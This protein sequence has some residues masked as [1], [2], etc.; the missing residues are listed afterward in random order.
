[1]TRGPSSPKLPLEVRT[2]WR[3]GN[4]LNGTPGTHLDLIWYSSDGF[5]ADLLALAGTTI[6]QLLPRA[7]GI[8]PAREPAAR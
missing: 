5:E 4:A 6:Q 8:L 7:P 2:G 3:C 1:M